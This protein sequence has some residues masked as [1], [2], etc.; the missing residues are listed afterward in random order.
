MAPMSPGS[1]QSVAPD[2][3]AIVMIE[4]FVITRIFWPGTRPSAA[5]HFPFSRMFGTQHSLFRLPV[6]APAQLDCKISPATCD[7]ASSWWRPSSLEQPP[8]SAAVSG[9]CPQYDG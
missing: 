8:V 5:S 6:L 1:H 4:P 2:T 9:L 3:G 7:A